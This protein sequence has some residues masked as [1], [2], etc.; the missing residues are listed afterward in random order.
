MSAD[1]ASVIAD[2][3]AR[4][5]RYIRWLES[6]ARVSVLIAVPASAKWT[7]SAQAR[8]DRPTVQPVIGR[9]GLGKPHDLL[10][11]DS[12]YLGPWRYSEGDMQ[13]V[14]W[15]APIADAYYGRG[16]HQDLAGDVQVTRAFRHKVNDI[17]DY[18]DERLD[19]ARGTTAFDRKT[20]LRISRPP[21]K[22]VP[23]GRSTP[24]PVRPPRSQQSASEQL[25]EP[26]QRHARRA[27]ADASALRH[28]DSLR[29]TLQAPRTA[30]LRQVLSTLQP[31]QHELVKW[32]SAHPLV[33]QGHPGAGKT[34][35]AVHRAAYLVHPE[36]PGGPLWG[37]VLL[38][39]PTTN[40]VSHTKT[41]LASLTTSPSV[42][43]L[44]THALL[45]R[46]LPELAQS[47]SHSDENYRDY[48][49]ELAGFVDRISE[50][51]WRRG[52][53]NAR[54]T[55][56]VAA[57]TVYETMRTNARTA[58]GD[59]SEYV[60]SLPVWDKALRLERFAPLLAYCAL[61]VKPALTQGYSHVIVDEAQDVRPMEWQ[62][63]RTLNDGRGWTVVG[64]MN[65]R[66]S[67]C[68][69]A[70]WEQITT[71]IGVAG[72][73]HV[74]DYRSVYRSTPAIQQ[75]AGRLLPARERT[76]IPV[77]AEGERPAVVK[78]SPKTMGEV[79]VAAASPFLDAHRQGTVAVIAVDPS[80]VRRAFV[81]HG[82]RAMGA[83][84]DTYLRAGKRIRLLSATD[85]R[86]LE[87]DAVVV[88]EPADFPKNLGR[89]G[90][91]Y[92]SLTRANRSLVVVH[93]KPLPEELRR[94]V[95]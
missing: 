81:S 11:T 75:F 91:L 4:N 59:W 5:Q 38:L 85:A 72:S 23:A 90:L 39:G 30:A 94:A 60:S 86:G 89:H 45:R 14:S 12:F 79:V 58:P 36:R 32:D 7:K 78:A 95:R 82:W 24:P 70:S 76:G 69:Y 21:G 92:T 83:G 16:D 77:Q 13:V 15:A 74:E 65:Q 3:Q 49:D 8:L 50:L 17:I 33:V 88:V 56:S 20:P 40:Y 31:R 9:V 22:P 63:L 25:P 1:R 10:G 35:L 28:A 66:R 47:P 67:D 26:A 42:E 6:R 41:A 29:K 64:D 18:D 37:R 53:L 61:R 80:S 54:M 51:L 44:S 48:D 57:R 68:C 84:R 27:L 19:N 71:A 55:P 87:F 34:I 46:L 62:I 93:T 52:A 2:E 43:A 73:A